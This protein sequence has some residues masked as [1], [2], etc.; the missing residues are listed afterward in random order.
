M[1]ST[2]GATPI[3]QYANH[4]ACALG[5]YVLNLPCPN[6]RQTND[7]LDV[8]T[9]ICE[10]GSWL[11]RYTDLLTNMFCYT[12]RLQGFVCSTPPKKHKPMWLVI[13]NNHFSPPFLRFYGNSRLSF[14]MHIARLGC[15]KCWAWTLAASLYPP[16]P[17]VS[18]GGAKK[19]LVL[20]SVDLST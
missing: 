5:T 1:L 4:G 20:A 9:V 15:H 12:R 7:Q 3:N 13:K 16:K 8:E 6:S 10:T 11:T 18:R 17:S 2:T 14:C 19:R